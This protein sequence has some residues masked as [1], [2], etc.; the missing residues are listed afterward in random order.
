MFSAPARICR[1]CFPLLLMLWSCTAQEKPVTRGDRCP[2]LENQDRFLVACD[3][4]TWTK[5]S[6]RR[7]HFL[8]NAA[9]PPLLAFSLPGRYVVPVNV[10][11][12]FLED[13]RRHDGR[14]LGFPRLGVTHQHLESP[15]LR[16]SL[17]MSP[18]QTGVMVTCVQVRNCVTQRECSGYT[19]VYYIDRGFC[20]CPRPACRFPSG[21]GWVC[22][23]P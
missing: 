23:T 13:V 11:E 18:Q 20:S 12:H 10:L 14:Y 16:G 8:P 4:C 7:C 9:P 21:R 5:F 2:G 15:A 1:C 22:D 3:Y 17:R 6:A 19:H